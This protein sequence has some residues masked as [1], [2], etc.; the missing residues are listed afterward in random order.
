LEIRQN[1]HGRHSD[2][3]VHAGGERVKLVDHWKR[4]IEARRSRRA[5]R[6]SLEVL[7]GLG[8]NDLKDIGLISSDIHAVKSGRIFSD[9]S[10]RQR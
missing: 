7:Y 5:L 4:F 6:K 3:R 1:S 9:A 2:G 8:R 10:R